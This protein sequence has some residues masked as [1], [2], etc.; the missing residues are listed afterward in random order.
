MI[1]ANTSLDEPTFSSTE[2]RQN[3]DYCL[4][5]QNL[6]P[7]QQPYQAPEKAAQLEQIPL[8]VYGCMLVCLFM[9]LF[10][11]FVILF[12]TYFESHNMLLFHFN[13]FNYVFFTFLLSC[14]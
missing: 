3:K 5:L 8:S 4:C 13:S 14:M 9:Y 6:Q 2:C 1:R 11:H 7:P 10:I 12:L